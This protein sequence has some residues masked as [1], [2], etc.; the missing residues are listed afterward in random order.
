MPSIQQLRIIKEAVI[1]Y[2]QEHGDRNYDD[3]FLMCF[4]VNTITDIEIKEEIEDLSAVI[5]KELFNSKFLNNESN[6]YS[7]A[8]IMYKDCR[9]KDYYKLEP[10][11]VEF[12][13]DVYLKKEEIGDEKYYSEVIKVVDKIVN[14]YEIAYKKIELEIK[15]DKEKLIEQE[16]IIE[17]IRQIC[18]GVEE[19]ISIYSDFQEI[20]AD[21][22]K[23]IKEARTLLA[24]F[25][26]IERPTTQGKLLDL[27]EES[28]FFSAAADMIADNLYTAG[29]KFENKLKVQS[30]FGSRNAQKRNIKL[31]KWKEDAKEKARLLW[32]N[33]STLLHN[34]MVDEIMKLDMFNKMPDGKYAKPTLLRTI[35]EVAGES[36][37][38]DRNLIFGSINKK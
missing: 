6:N 24:D 26:L 37:F 4:M 10:Y 18:K 29:V 25:E 12:A 30:E 3:N 31:N 33:G 2:K 11:L 21:I 32:R 8:S 23:H 9:Q 28:M 5:Q 13:K 17:E 15:S 35:K 1:K 7:S 19:N 36:E 22:A 34:K 20:D 16:L 14:Q 38:K 27:S